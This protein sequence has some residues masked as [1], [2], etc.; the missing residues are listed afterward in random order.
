MKPSEAVI[1]IVLYTQICIAQTNSSGYLH[2]PPPEFIQGIA[3]S[4]TGP[5]FGQKSP[6]TKP[7]IFAPGILTLPNEVVAVTRIAFSPDGKECFYS[8]PTDW[9]Y[10]GTR[11]YYTKCVNNV[12]TPHELVSFFPG[13]SCRQP[14]FSADGNTLYFSSDKNGNSDIWMVARTPEGWGTPQVLPAPI[15]T[16]SYDGMYTQASD[17]TVYIESTRPGGKGGIDVW[18]INPQQSGQPLQ[19]ENLGLPVNSGG[20]DND[21]VVSPDGRYIIFGTNYNDLFI[22]FNK[23]NGRWTAP[24]NLNQ[25]YPGINTVNQEYAPNITHDGRY[26]FFTC[27]S[28]YWV[29]TSPI[30]SMRKP[31]F[32]PYEKNAIPD[33]KAKKDSLF[34]YQIPDSTFFDDDGSNTLI[35]SAALSNS[36]PLPGWLSF[37]SKTR[38][39]SGTPA[40]AVKLTIKVF[41][42]DTANASCSCVFRLSVTNPAG[43]LSHSW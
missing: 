42:T 38:T 14:Y 35:Y 28:V 7:Q 10:S 19:A 25:Y 16:S 8:G 2:Q 12:W 40:A 18:R 9:N 36:N 29:S 32:P 17:G 39:F 31:N 6:G 30:D 26:L 23:G 37:S 11:M 27:G 4:V 24:V 3:D 34:N 1:A 41:A 5:Y 33:Q 13:Y 20:D 15:N 43:P 21:P 22:T